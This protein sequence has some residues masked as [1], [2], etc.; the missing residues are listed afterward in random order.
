MVVSRGEKG[1]R[2]SIWIPETEY[3][4]YDVIAK[5]QRQVEQEKGVT[6]SQGQILREVLVDKLKG[7]KDGD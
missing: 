6:I 3:W 7:L 4:L 1:R 5:I 2:I